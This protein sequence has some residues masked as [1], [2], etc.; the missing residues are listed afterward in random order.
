MKRL[1]KNGI[2]FFIA[3]ALVLLGNSCN[4]QPKQELM[5]ASNPVADAVQIVEDAQPVA[6]NVLKEKPSSTKDPSSSVSTDIVE[7]NQILENTIYPEINEEIP[8]FIQKKEITLEDVISESY[9]QN[10]QVIEST[11]DGEFNGW[12]GET[13]Y[14]LTNGQ[15]WQQSSYYYNYSY[16]Y[17]PDVLIYRSGTGYKMLVEGE[18][19]A[20]DV[21]RLTDVI[22]SKVEGDFEGWEGETV[23]R[24][25]N[26]QVWQQSAYHYHYHYAYRPDVLIYKDGYGYKMIVVDDDDEPISVRLLN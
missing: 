14:K 2:Y 13:L 10:D 18:S 1:A 4:N 7:T 25:T 16:D 6:D 22:E 5:D 8:Y 20:V 21:Q 17:R 9:H 3:I 11:I 15:F 19:K 23:Y 24:L 12:S 26:G